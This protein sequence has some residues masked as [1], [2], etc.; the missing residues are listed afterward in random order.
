MAVRFLSIKITADCSRPFAKN[1]ISFFAYDA[2]NLTSSLSL[3]ERKLLQP[4]KSHIL[5]SKLVSLSVF[6]VNDVYALGG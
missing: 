5:S 3:F 2:S 6:S 4:V 1:V